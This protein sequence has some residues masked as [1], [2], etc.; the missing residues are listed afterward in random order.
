MKD[1]TAVIQEME[2]DPN[3]LCILMFDA[4]ESIQDNQG[5]L[6][7]LMSDTYLVDPFTNFTGDTYDI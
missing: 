1:I 2:K 5:G 7:Q 6:R 4:N 3:N